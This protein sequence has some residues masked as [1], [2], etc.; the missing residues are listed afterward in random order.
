MDYQLT[1]LVC[2]LFAAEHARAGHAWGFEWGYLY[3]MFSKKRAT[4][5]SIDKV[6]AASKCGYRWMD[7]ARSVVGV[8][9]KAERVEPGR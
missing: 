2:S 9:S 6:K 4:A 1:L 7:V 3:D 5:G 8:E